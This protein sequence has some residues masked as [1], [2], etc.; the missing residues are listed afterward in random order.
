MPA[1]GEGMDH[2]EARGS[3]GCGNGGN[4]NA[5]DALHRRRQR[6]KEGERQVANRLAKFG[7]VKTVPRVN[8]IEL[9]QPRGTR[10]FDDTHQIEARIGDGPRAVG[11]SD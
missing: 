7:P 2:R 10:A 8:G 9:P 5:W 6:R 1:A 11:K 3:G 4:R